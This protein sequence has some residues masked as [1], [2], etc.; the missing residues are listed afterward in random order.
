MCVAMVSTQVKMD[1]NAREYLEV[2]WYEEK[3]K[4]IFSSVNDVGFF[5]Q[6]KVYSMND[7]EW[8][9][10]LVFCIIYSMNDRE[11]DNMLVF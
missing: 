7:R 1:A 10:V 8:D 5:F 2:L 6:N 3:Y 9:N 4:K 11:W